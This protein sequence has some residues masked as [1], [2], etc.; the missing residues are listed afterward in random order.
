M[1]QSKRYG[2]TG[3]HTQQ[4]GTHASQ[5]EAAVCTEHMGAVEHVER[6]Q[7]K[8]RSKFAN[9]YEQTSVAEQGKQRD[10]HVAV[11]HAVCSSASKRRRLCSIRLK[12]NAQLGC[13]ATMG[14]CTLVSAPL[15]GTLAASTNSSLP[16]RPG[17]PMH[18]PVQ[19]FSPCLLVCTPACGRHARP[20]AGTLCCSS[21]PACTGCTAAGPQPAARRSCSSAGCPDQLP[22]RAVLALQPQRL[23]PLNQLACHAAAAAA[24]LRM[25]ARSRGKGHPA[26]LST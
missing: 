20:A 9:G 12:A 4:C 21:A 8:S 16:G 1:S 22:E 25:S 11:R 26:R 17:Q 13:P 24:L 19:R 3:E 10:T 14:N 7:C 23:L 6:E 5:G 18:T 2:A 15:G